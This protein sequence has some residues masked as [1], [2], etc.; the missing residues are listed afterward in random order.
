MSRQ[1]ERFEAMRA[2]A[3]ERILISAAKLF[4]NKTFAK[5]TM[6]DIADDAGLSKGLAYRYFATKEEIMSNL[7]EISIPGIE[8]ITALFKQEGNEKEVVMKV[9]TFLLD[10][11]KVDPSSTDGLFLFSQIDSFSEKELSSELK[12]AVRTSMKKLIDNISDVILA[13]QKQGYFKSGDP[14][15]Y[16]M[17]YYSIFQGVAFTSR[18]FHEEYVYPTAEM[19]LDFLIKQT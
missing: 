18:S 1:K 8:R 4:A 12:N 3:T 9:T 16:A 14:R 17:F 2:E 11:L 5:T 6:Q 19:F 10:N 7:I 13:G 15:R